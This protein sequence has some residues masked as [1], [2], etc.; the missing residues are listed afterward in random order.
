MPIVFGLTCQIVCVA[1]TCSTSDVPIPNAMAPNAPCVAVCESPQTMTFPGCVSPRSGPTTWTMPCLSSPIEANG[2]PN[3][4][5]F[6]TK[7]S[8][9]KRDIWSSILK[10]SFVGTL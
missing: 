5:A 2:T 7:V 6:F 4:C 10:M 8:I 9:C 3:S 1:I